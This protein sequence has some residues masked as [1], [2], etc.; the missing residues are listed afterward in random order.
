M[1]RFLIRF[2]PILLPL[3]LYLI[4]MMRQRARARRNGQPV[5]ALRDGPV[6]WTLAA[7]FMALVLCFIWTMLM[8]DPLAGTY[9]PAH[10]ENGVIV[11]ARVL[12][13]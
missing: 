1:L 5:P 10:M 13:K 2:W 7:T 6:G 3:V 9:I 11:P 12:E 4:W 8:A